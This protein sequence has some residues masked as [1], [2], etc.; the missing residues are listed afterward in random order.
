M[1]I[2]EETTVENYISTDD[3]TEKFIYNRCGL[4]ILRFFA[5]HPNGRFSTM[6]V[7]HAIDEARN[8]LEVKNTL[9]RMVEDGILRINVEN[10]TCFY[11]LA[12]DETVRRTVFSLGAFDWRNWQ[13]ILEHT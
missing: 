2:A 8:R 6:A 7:I 3:L 5:L 9:D 12:T 11:T 4:D 13:M 1:T 10:N